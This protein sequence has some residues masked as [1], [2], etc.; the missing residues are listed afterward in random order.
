[1]TH[2][3]IVHLHLIHNLIGGKDPEKSALRYCA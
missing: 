2:P 1:M 3:E